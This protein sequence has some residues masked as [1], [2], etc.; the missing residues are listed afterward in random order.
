MTQVM[1][2]L[3]VIGVVVL[4]PLVPAIWLFRQ[5]PLTRKRVTAGAESVQQDQGIN[6]A[7]VPAPEGQVS[8]T[9]GGMV[10]KFGGAAAGYFAVFIP[11]MAIAQPELSRQTELL[12]QIDRD[13]VAADRYEVVQLHGTVILEREESGHVP[14]DIRVRLVPP[15]VQ[16]MPGGGFVFDVP[17]R[18]HHG[19]RSFPTIVFDH[20]GYA[21]FPLCLTSKSVCEIGNKWLDQRPIADNDIQLAQPVVLPVLNPYRGGPPLRESAPPP[22]PARLRGGTH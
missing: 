13:I 6:V 12:K 1:T 19:Q 7:P 21:G 3:V 10:Y 9:L 11:L 22:A 14:T 18:N 4:L 2:S 16:I 5:I 17:V 15:S 8:G 20:E